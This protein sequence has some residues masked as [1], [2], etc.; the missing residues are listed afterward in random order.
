MVEGLIAN[1]VVLV[2]IGIILR[3]FFS[4]QE[5]QAKARSRELNTKMDTLGETMHLLQ[6]GMEGKLGRR[7]HEIGCRETLEDVW[8][9]INNHCHTQDGNVVI[10]RGR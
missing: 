7:E 8:A 6:L 3:Y 9:R 2:I 10:P 1:V 4:A 5:E